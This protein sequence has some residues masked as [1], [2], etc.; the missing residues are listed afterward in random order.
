MAHRSVHVGHVSRSF[1]LANVRVSKLPRES[2]KV[3]HLLNNLASRPTRLLY[4]G[5]YVSSSLWGNDLAVH[6]LD[7]Q[8]FEEA[9]PRPDV[10]PYDLVIVDKDRVQPHI[11][12]YH[13]DKLA[14][15]FVFAVAGW[16][17]Q[18]I[19]R[20]VDRELRRLESKWDCVFQVAINDSGDRREWGDGAAVFVLQ[21]NPDVT[22]STPSPR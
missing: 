18:D 10:Y 8:S 14:D 11:L 13:S 3:H 7:D 20:G 6:W 9:T 2:S 17:S 15:D 5:R 1:G 19:R 21:K 12:K 4:V 16:N 22:V